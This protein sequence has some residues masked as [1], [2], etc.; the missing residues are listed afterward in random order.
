MKSCNPVAKRTLKAMPQL[1]RRV[2][3]NNTLGIVPMP[4]VVPTVPQLVVVKTYH[5]ISS[6]AHSRIVTQH[7]INALTKSTIEK[8][9]DIFAPHV[10]SKAAPLRTAIQP[11]HVACPM[12]HPITGKTIS[13]YKRL[14]NNPATAETWQTAFGKVVGGMLQGDNKMG[15][16]ET[17][18]MFVI[19]HGKIRHVLATGQKF[20]YGSLVVGYRLQKEDPHR[21][22]ILAGGNFTT[23]MWSPSVRTADLDMAKLHWNSVI[24]TKGAKYMC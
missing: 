2:T 8:C 13:S 12:V 1:H 14:M 10:L 7:A 24:S 9:Q 21:V 19:T 20:T 6:G 5:P 11:E 18:V 4:P 3:R 22:C 16:K 23:Y 15:Q 17:N